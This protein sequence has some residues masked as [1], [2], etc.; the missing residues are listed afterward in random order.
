MRNY[1]WRKIWRLT[2]SR[3]SNNA[4][5]RRTVS[6]SEDSRERLL[7]RIKY[8]P[9]FALQIDGSA[10]VAGLARLLVSVRWLGTKHSERVNVLSTALTAFYRE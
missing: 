2:T 10:D 3:L 7:T 6:L 5:M 1:V 8:C 4:I 9:K